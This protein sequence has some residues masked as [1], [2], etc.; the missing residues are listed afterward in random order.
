MFFLLIHTFSPPSP[1][2]IHQLWFAGF[3]EVKPPDSPLYAYKMAARDKPP[4]KAPPPLWQKGSHSL[5]W[6]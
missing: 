4:E 1:T 3:G 6:P 2:P 5:A